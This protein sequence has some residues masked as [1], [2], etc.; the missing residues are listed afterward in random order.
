CCWTAA[1]P[2]FM[3]SCAA[4]ANSIS[5]ECAEG[6][7]IKSV[8]AAATPRSPRTFGLKHSFMTA[9]LLSGEGLG[10]DASL[11]KREQ[12]RSWSAAP[13]HAPD[14]LSKRRRHVCPENGSGITGLASAP[15]NCGGHEKGRAWSARP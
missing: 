10:N 2:R 5:W 7:Q 12:P 15:M 11:S 14:E 6:R 8:A 4:G 13:F 3:E 1:K 9:L